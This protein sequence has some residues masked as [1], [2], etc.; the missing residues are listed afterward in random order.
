[1]ADEGNPRRSGQ[2]SGPLR[3]RPL[4]LQ[5]IPMSRRLRRA[6]FFAAKEIGKRNRQREPIP[7]AVPFGILPHRPGGCGPLEIPRGLRGT[8]DEKRETGVWTGIRIATA[9]VRTGFA[10]ITCIHTTMNEIALPPS[11]G[12]APS[13]RELARSA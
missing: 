7:K 10:I 1:M 2:S 3:I 9:G 13:L 4:S 5:F 11:W 6:D 8:M 12:V